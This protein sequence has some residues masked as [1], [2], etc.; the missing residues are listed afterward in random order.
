MTSVEVFAVVDPPFRS[1][2]V[3]VPPPVSDQRGLSRRKELLLSIRL[4]P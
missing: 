3:S 1:G 2:T 4:V